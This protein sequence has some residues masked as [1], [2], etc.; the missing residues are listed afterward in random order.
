MSRTVALLM[1]AA[2]YLAAQSL[3][4]PEQ[5]RTPAVHA[6]KVQG[7]VWLLVGAGANIAMQTGKEGVMLVDTGAP[8]LT[9]AVLAAIRQV[10]DGPIR[11]VVNTSLGPDRIGGNAVLAALPG[12]STTGKGH[13]PMP[14]LIAHD[15]VLLRMSTPHPDGKAPYPVAAWPSDGY[16]ASHRNVFF[17]GEVVDILHKPAAHT[18]GDSIVYF[19]GSNVIVSGDIFTTTN[20]PLID[21]KQGGSSRGMLDALNAMLDIAVPENMQEGGTYIIPGRGRVCD[22]ADLVEYRDMLHQIRDRM[23]NLVNVQHLTL[24]Q[25]KAKRSVLGWEGR[26]SRPEWTTD[27]FVEA[28]YD[29]FKGTGK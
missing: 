28:L 26:Y 29:E 2:G 10:T 8:G 5:P 17:N 6:F 25:V 3:S 24:E 20:L 15:N 11:Y 22:E 23:Q 16:Q 1:L 21:R 27:M 13:G 4:E 19:R 14:A 12:G 7:N 18:D 9:D